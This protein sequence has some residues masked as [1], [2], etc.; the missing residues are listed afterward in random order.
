[1]GHLALLCCITGP[2]EVWIFEHRCRRRGIASSELAVFVGK[3]NICTT[4]GDASA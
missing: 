1:M 2:S 3:T 4:G